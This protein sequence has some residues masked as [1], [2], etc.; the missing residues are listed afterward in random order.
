MFGVGSGY[1]AVWVLAMYLTT[2][3]PARL[4]YGV[5]SLPI[6]LPPETFAGG[7]YV[8]FVGVAAGIGLLAVAHLRRASAAVP[9]TAS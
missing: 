9:K 6:V 2:E 1:L 4:L 8:N 3:H 5:L 7:Y